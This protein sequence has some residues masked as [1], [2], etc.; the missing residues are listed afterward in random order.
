MES[1]FGSFRGV[2][3]SDCAALRAALCLAKETLFTSLDWITRVC[4]SAAHW[5]LPLSKV[6]PREDGHHK[7]SNFS[8]A[9]ELVLG[10]KLVAQQF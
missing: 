9:G 3:E 8:P 10:G 2:F 4:D 1:G 6:V 7:F 5:I